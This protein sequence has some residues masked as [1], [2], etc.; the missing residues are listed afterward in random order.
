MLEKFSFIISKNQNL[1]QREFLFTLENNL[2]GHVN[3]FSFF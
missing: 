2:G 1:P 3:F